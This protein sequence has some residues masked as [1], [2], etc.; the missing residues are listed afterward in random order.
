[1]EVYLNKVLIVDGSY[2]LH[3]ALHVPG[4]QDLCTSTGVKSGGVYGFFKILQSEIK[5]LPGYFPIVCWD[6][7]LSQRRIDIYQDYKNHLNRL[8]TNRLIEAG[9][10]PADE[11]LEEYHRQRADVSAISSTAAFNSTFSTSYPK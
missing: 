11:Y 9:L 10:A 6:K 2:A 7:G 1:M 8:E 4:L 3:R 5:K